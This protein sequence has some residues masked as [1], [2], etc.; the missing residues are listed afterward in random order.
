MEKY[1]Y[2]SIA[3]G[4]FIVIGVA[5]F[6]WG[7]NNAQA[8]VKKIPQEN[9][10]APSVTIVRTQDGYE[11]S[12]VTIKKGNVILWTNESGDFHWPASDIHPTHS[13]YPEFDPL[14]PVADGEDWSFR[15]DEVG[16]WKF[17]DHLRSN[18]IGTVTVTE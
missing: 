3:V 15:F 14:R 13:I 17:H 18:K 16:V 12:E 1:K 6:V 7:Q 4:V 8:P 10:G 9:L 5:L 2:I 11:P